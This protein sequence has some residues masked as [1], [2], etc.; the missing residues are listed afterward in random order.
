MSRPSDLAGA[1]ILKHFLV[2]KRLGDG[3]F[4]EVFQADDMDSK[5]VVAIKIEPPTSAI[6]PLNNEYRLYQ[7]LSG[8]DGIPT[9]YGIHEYCRG[10][11][12]V[13][14]RLGPS[15][16][17][18][19]RRCGR[20]FTLKTVLMIADQMFRI[21]QWVHQCGIVHRDIKPHNFVTGRGP[22]QNKIFLIDFGISVPYLDPRTHEHRDSSNH[23]GFVGTLQY[24]SINAHFGDQQSRRDDMESVMYVLLRFLRGSLPWGDLKDQ[25][26]DVCLEKVTQLKLQVTVDVLCQSLPVEFKEVLEDIRKLAYEATPNY[27]WIRARFRNVFVKSGFVYDGLFD[28]DDIAPIHKPIP[29]VF[30]RQSAGCFQFW[31]ERQLKERKR[32]VHLPPHR[33]IFIAKLDEPIA[34]KGKMVKKEI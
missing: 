21:L 34:Q 29:H 1:T 20:Q 33:P 6:S 13:M 26:S 4:G 10:R 23:N 31:N 19:F 17:T 22:L 24:V 7:W 32:R 8:M 25:D 11:A 5:R 2:G 28:W 16:E 9:V 30:L 3:A 15:L 12:M 27:S 14:E 18:L